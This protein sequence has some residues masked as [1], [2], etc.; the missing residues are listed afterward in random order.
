MKI[1]GVAVGLTVLVLGF[2]NCSKARFS[3]DDV[4]KANTLQT[5]GLL[6]DGGIDPSTPTGGFPNDPGVDP[7]NPTP[8]N[9]GTDPSNP[10]GN[11]SGLSLYANLACPRLDAHPVNKTFAT[12]SSAIKIVFAKKSGSEITSICEVHDVKA[13]IL[14]R[15]ADLTRQIDI[16]ACA[17]VLPQTPSTGINVYVVEESVTSDY[18]KYKFNEDVRYDGVVRT[19]DLIFAD[20]EDDANA[21]SCDS[22]GD[23]LVIQLGEAKN[24]SL[25]AANAGVMF[26]LLGKRNDHVKVQTAWFASADENYFLVLPDEKGEVSGVDQL[27]GD[28]TQGPDQ[29]FSKQGFEA[30][31][32][33]D[34]NNDHLIDAAD[35]VF[36]KLKLWKDS[37]L[38][39][40]AQPEELFTLEEKHV[41]LLDLRYDSRYQKRDKYGNRV[42]F[43]SVVVLEDGKHQIMSDLWLRYVSPK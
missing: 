30:L 13:Q 10:G 15:H 19:V 8:N 35:E 4:A 39:G 33:H 24:L 38:D 18:A 9:P 40:I 3:V 26:D 42:K 32:K 37:N 16:S 41:V 29:K 23:P 28:N 25:T 12:S 31:A 21:N 34:D 27:F 17:S 11:P 7:S 43:K 1:L 20:T 14:N 6:D 22:Q 2:Q 5:N 36:S